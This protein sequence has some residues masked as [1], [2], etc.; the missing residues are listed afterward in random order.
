[1]NR[2]ELKKLGI[3]F[4]DDPMASCSFDFNEH[5]IHIFLD[6]DSLKRCETT[7]D[8]IKQIVLQTKHKFIRNGKTE[9]QRE[10][11]DLFDKILKPKRL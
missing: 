5:A 6:E 10:I 11:N 2:T 1:M 8:V 4:D 3:R 7:I 9:R